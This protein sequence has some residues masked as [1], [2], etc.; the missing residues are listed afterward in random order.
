VKGTEIYALAIELLNEGF[1]LYF[2]GCVLVL[3]G[4]TP[5]GCCPHCR[6]AFDMDGCAYAERSDYYFK[7]G[8]PDLA[9]RIVRVRCMN[10]HGAGRVIDFEDYVNVA[11]GQN[12]P[13]VAGG[14]VA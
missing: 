13:A 11:R 3:I 7:H 6:K 10:L 1:S 9:G 14:G 12:T 8:D 2:D 4:D 5:R